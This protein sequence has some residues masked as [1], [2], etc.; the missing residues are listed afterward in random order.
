MV[1]YSRNN[2][3]P[4][5]LVSDIYPCFIEYFGSSKFEEINITITNGRVYI[6][7]KSCGHTSE[8]EAKKLSN[9]K[10]SFTPISNTGINYSTCK[11]IG[12]MEGNRFV[13]NEAQGNDNNELVENEP[14]TKKNIDVDQLVSEIYPKFEEYLGSIPNN[15]NIIIENDRIFIQSETS[16]HSTEH[17]AKKLSNGKWSFTPISNTGIDYSTSENALNN[18]RKDLGQINILIAGRTGVG[19]STLINA[20]FNQNLAVTGVG[21]PITQDIKEL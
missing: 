4:N 12:R 1:D 2:I 5:K 3:D 6:Q 14:I 20:I 8:H 13:S 9:G 18:F 17:E 11:N 15:V 19:K 7:S 10:W 21:R 16:G